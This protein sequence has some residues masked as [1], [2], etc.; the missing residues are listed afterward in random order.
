MSWL[1]KTR[2]VFLEK[3]ASFTAAVSL[4]GRAGAKAGVWVVFRC[5]ACTCHIVQLPQAEVYKSLLTLCQRKGRLCAWGREGWGGKNKKK[6]KRKQTKSHYFNETSDLT[7]LYFP[8]SFQHVLENNFT[9][10]ASCVK[11]QTWLCTQRHSLVFSSSS[12]ISCSHHGLNFNPLMNYMN[13]LLLIPVGLAHFVLL[14]LLFG[15]QMSQLSPSAH[16]FGFW[17][18]QGLRQRDSICH[19]KSSMS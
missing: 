10:P 16:T 9:F 5:W 6:L 4:K 12:Y 19:L 11:P 18:M 17:L 8:L 2:Q 15:H 3:I 7:H 14:V 1:I 13:S